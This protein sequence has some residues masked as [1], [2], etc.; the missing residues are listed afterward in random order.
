MRRHKHVSVVSAPQT[1]EEG[2]CSARAEALKLKRT[3]KAEVATSKRN[4]LK[5]DVKSKKVEKL[6]LVLFSAWQ[7]LASISNWQISCATNQL[8]KQKCLQ[9]TEPHIAKLDGSRRF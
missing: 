5:L 7:Y 1:P 2:G 3:V 9:R 6:D 8:A 4:T